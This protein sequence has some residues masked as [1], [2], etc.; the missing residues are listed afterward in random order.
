MKPRLAPRGDVTVNVVARQ[1]REIVLETKAAVGRKLVRRLSGVVL[2]CF[3]KWSSCRSML[4]QLS[5]LFDSSVLVMDRTALPLSSWRF[6]GG[7]Q[8]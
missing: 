7:L 8:P 5:V 1:N 4:T 2:I 6:S 3:I